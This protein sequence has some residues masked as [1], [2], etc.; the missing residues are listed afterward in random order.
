MLSCKALL[1]FRFG[2]EQVCRAIINPMQ[3]D[4]VAKRRFVLP[5]RLFYRQYA[6]QGPMQE[7][8]RIDRLN[9]DIVELNPG[10]RAFSRRFYRNANDADD[11]VQETLVRALGNLDR[12]EEGT[13]LK[14]WLF[15]IM[16]NTFCSRFAVARREAPGISECVADSR[17]S[18]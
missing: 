4:M 10:L 18:E 9:A 1:L 15:T 11:L 6:G 14:S 7:F 12:F 5:D 2:K 13:K 17:V 16:R 3:V 8:S